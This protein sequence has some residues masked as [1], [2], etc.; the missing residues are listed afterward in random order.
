MKNDTPS[1][2]EKYKK[3]NKEACS[4]FQNKLVVGNNIRIK[5][6]VAP[7]K[8][9]NNE[10]V[11]TNV[12]GI[13]LL[14]EVV[15]MD[16]A[17]VKRVELHC[18]T[19]MSQMDAVTPIKKLVQ[20][21]IKWGL[22]SLAITDHGV[23][24][25][26]PF[27]HNAA[28]GSDLK[29][30]YGVEAYLW[31]G[32]EKDSRYYHIIV[33]AKDAEGLFNLYKL[34][35]LSHLQYFGG[36]RPRPRMTRAL[37]NEYRK[38]LIIG[39][40][41]A[42]GELYQAILDQESEEEIL[43]IAKFYDYVEIQPICNNQ[44]IVRSPK[45]PAITC[46]KDLEK[47][48]KYIYDLG[49]K[50]GKLTVATCDVHF[51]N[52]EDAIMRSM[53]LAGQKFKDADEKLPL[54]F[55]TTEE[56]LGEFAYLGKDIAYEVV[57]TNTNLISD[58][59]TKIK[60]VPDEEFLYSPHIP[61][62]EKKIEDMTY[63]KAHALYGDELPALVQER[64]DM[65]LHSIIGNGFAV[66]YY[67]AHMLVKKSNDDGYMVGSRGS[68]GSS[69]VA[70]MIDITEVNPLKP[71]Y[72]CPECRYNEFIMDNSVG[73]GFDLEPK[74]CPHCGADMVRDG[75]DI[76][77]A[78][79]MGF[80]GE[81][82]PD[83]DLNFSGDYQPKAHKY[84]EELFGRD[85]VCRAGTLGT[86]QD[87]TAYGYVKGYFNDR[88][89]NVKRAFVE[90]LIP[91]IVGVKRTSGQHPGGILVVPRGLDI[92][93][94][95][96]VQHPAN[97]M[98]S[99]IITTHFDYHSINDRMVKLDILGHDDPTVIKMLEVLL[100]IDAKSIPVGDPETISI[101]SSTTA[102]GVTPEAIGSKV[103]TFG[104]PECGTKFVR[105]MLYDVQPKN[106]TDLLRVSGYSHGTD[107]WLNNAQDLIVAG[108]PTEETISTRD[109]IMTYLIGHNVEPSMAFEIMEYCR[110]GKAHK[111]GLTEKQLAALHGANISEQYI[112]SCCTVQYLF[113]K[114]H[115]A[116]YVLMAYRIAY[117]KVHEPLAFYAAYFT[118]RAPKFDYTMVRKGKE[119]M[120]NYI[121]QIN[122]KGNEASVQEKE[123]NTY[124]ELAV[125]LMERGFEF[126][127]IDLYESDAHNFQIMPNG[128]RPPLCALSGVG[129][130]AAEGIARAR[131]DKVFNSKEEL[132]MDAKISSAA[133][134]ALTEVG[135][136]DGL[137][138]SPMI[139]LF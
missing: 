71:H 113:P 55:R 106:F 126:Y 16:T 20:T 104:I 127:D 47:I 2:L 125:E 123:N 31:S 42:A 91:G 37:I 119:F 84:T 129:G 36:R 49:K 137:P 93:Y 100:K 57:V 98:K 11:M 63:A 74:A 102:L 32:D 73:S 13:Q 45:Y 109:D 23:V 41:C 130:S 39:S 138:D 133:I 103:G 135:A 117:C 90:G 79:F 89:K 40:A 111:M 97:D 68:V 110:K 94:I 60:P 72:R 66:L 122:N 82:V 80:H 48:N 87:R 17:E 52:P 7:D 101:F 28:K 62:A 132:K 3:T 33:L 50:L 121:E 124:M 14:P 43:D 30:I 46:D 19:M 69:F 120:K 8:Y 22:K 107:V 83:I 77:F 9:E 12:K 29:L 76:P 58:L 92:H 21:A 54:F 61:G 116:A 88:G 26:F 95:T 35:S 108:V 128:V 139:E 15:R 34:I 70:T 25:A 44:Y 105:E 56:M 112:R 27:A 1:E 65:E 131:V 75:H 99:N 81:K 24:Q 86:I 59:T 53:L 85:N 118:V 64:I 10:M 5:G 115:A 18:H 38:G 51:L 96:P 136:L 78:V 6:N 134:E 114:A 67:I 4:A